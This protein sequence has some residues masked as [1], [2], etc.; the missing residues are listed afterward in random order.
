MNSVQKCLDK[1]EVIMRYIWDLE[2]VFP[3]VKS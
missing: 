1:G 3:V 2:D